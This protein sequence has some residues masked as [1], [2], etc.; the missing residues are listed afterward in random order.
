MSEGLIFSDL[1]LVYIALTLSTFYLQGSLGHTI[2]IIVLHVLIV[3]RVL[4][5]AQSL[6]ILFV[7]IPGSHETRPDAGTQP[8]TY[9]ST[10]CLQGSLGHMKPDQMQALNPILI[11]LLILYRDPLAT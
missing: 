7:G 4:W 2:L 10:H 3:C 8:N 1:C 5:V 9:H 6:P 11:I